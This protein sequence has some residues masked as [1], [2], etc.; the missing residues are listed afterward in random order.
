MKN[1][2]IIQNAYLKKYYKKE[3][4]TA[5]YKDS[6]HHKCNISP[7]LT[8]NICVCVYYFGKL[9]FTLSFSRTW[10]SWFQNEFCTKSNR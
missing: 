5:N 6:S 10:N 2:K 3:D 9:L 7:S 8:K 4:V 1:L